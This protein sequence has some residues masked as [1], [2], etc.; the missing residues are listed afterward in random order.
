MYKNQTHD[1]IQAEEASNEKKI[2]S[3]IYFVYNGGQPHGQRRMAKLVLL[4]EQDSR[5]KMQTRSY[6][7]LLKVQTKSNHRLI[8]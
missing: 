4:S 8:M 7:I 3:M 1:R 5:A 2:L 6:P